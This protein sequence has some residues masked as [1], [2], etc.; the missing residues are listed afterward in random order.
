MSNTYLTVPQSAQY[1]PPCANVFGTIDGVGKRCRCSNSKGV[2]PF[3]GDFD[4]GFEICWYCQAEL[5]AS[6]S[7]WSTFYCEQ[8]RPAVLELN[9]SLDARGLV[10]LPIG[11]HSLMHGKWRHARPFTATAIVTEWSASRL[12]SGWRLY[13]GESHPAPW[14]EFGQF[15][16]EVR[17]REHP[18][19]IQ[20]IAALVQHAEPDVLLADLRV[21]NA[22]LARRRQPRP[23]T[24][25]SRRAP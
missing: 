22:E 17:E 16:R 19:A 21:A 18:L 9:D 25:G 20:Q 24:Q 13:G 6:G 14:A 8:C 11:R 3:H 5:I 7:R 2:R 1:C 12:R 15:Q 4:S 23:T 10:S